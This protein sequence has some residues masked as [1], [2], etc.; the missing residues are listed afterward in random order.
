M[1][2]NL[3]WDME[4]CSYNVENVIVYNTVMLILQ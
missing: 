1:F 4:M 3:K 2:Y